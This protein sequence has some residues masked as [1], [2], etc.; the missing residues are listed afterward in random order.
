MEKVKVLF[1]GESWF[2]TTIET[3]GFDQF[4]IGGYQTEI[5]RVRAF[6]KDVADITHIPAHEVLEHFPESVEELRA[7]DVIILSD[8]GANT[9]LLHPDTFFR[10]ETT[11]NRL[12]VIADYVKEGGAFGMMGGYLSFTGFEAKAKYRRTPVEE[13]LPVTMMAEDDR[14]EHPEGLTLQTA[15]SRHPLLHG[16]EDVWTPLLGYNRLCAKPGADVIISWQGDPILTVGTYG[17]GRTFAWAS[18]CAPHWMPVAFCESA[19]N[20][21]MWDNVLRWAA[22]K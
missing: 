9:F 11:P 22:G 2:F 1:A 14:E 21:A 13:I 10:S 12:Q 6:T 5:E 20:R 8:V 3:K 19:N 18:D 7:Y 15:G 4:T 16:C 17:K